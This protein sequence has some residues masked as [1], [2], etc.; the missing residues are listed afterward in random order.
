MRPRRLWLA[1]VLAA[2]CFPL[3]VG[4]D[5]PDLE[6][7][8]AI[9]SFAVDRILEVG[10]WLAPKSSPSE[11]E[12]FLEKPPLKFW[13]VAAP[14]ELGLLPHNEFGLRFWDAVFG[15]LAFLYVFAIGSLLA[16]PACGATAVLLLFVHVPLVLM[17]G[18]R[19]NNMEA[20]LLLSYCGGVYHFLRWAGPGDAGR[21]RRHAFA[22]G[23]YFA[24]GFMTKFV[25]AL[26]FPFV[27]VLAVIGSPVRRQRLVT[28]WRTWFAVGAVVL[29]LCAPWFVYAYS[30]FGAQLW[31]TILAEHVV[32]RLTNY[33]D[34]AHLQPWDFYVRVMWTS[35]SDEHVNWIALAGLTTLLV[36]TIRR[37]WFD[38]AV[39]L[40][41]AVVPLAIISTGTS[42]LYHYAF[43]FLPP[44]AL[45][46]GYLVS[47]VLML[48]PVP[49]RRILEWVE[50]RAGAAIPAMRAAAASPRA[51]RAATV[52]VFVSA[53][54]AVGALALG[55]VRIDVG[56][57]T[58]F[59]SSGVWRPLAVIVAAA[60]ATRTSARVSRL[61][62]VILVLNVLPLAAYREQLER[63]PDGHHPMRAA[64]E[65]LL[66]VQADAGLEP[67]IVF[68]M[69]EG[70]WHPLYYYFRRV[71]PVETVATPLDPALRGYLTDPS[72]PR[73]ILIS[74]D[75]YKQ[76]VAQGEVPSASSAIS[77]PMLSFLNTLLLL[78]GPYRVC[79]S[80]AVLHAAH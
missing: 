8:E 30:R 13:I 4:L 14:I 21:R 59:R 80:E 26:F 44:I 40:L 63:L 52:L 67:G 11:T 71:H 18:V 57:A 48:A 45:A 25:A 29:A 7:D 79:S 46:G 43:P 38:G 32:R 34:P 12:V 42:K 33:L 23:L 72:T 65:C 36:Q 47:L 73:P 69:P 50:D 49:L 2:F 77:P 10:D 24:L 5:R 51:H 22:A 75:V 74:E 62:V 6:T 55:H 35:W 9:Y 1:L 68:D 31:N 61:I 70:V 58:L 28:E 39:V 53:A 66:R 78:P 20:P 16:G 37:R 41:W 56:D 54:L 17:H 15:G 19:T 64:S 3:F 76:L 60:V 27:L